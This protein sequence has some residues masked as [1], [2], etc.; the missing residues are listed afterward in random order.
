MGY[1]TGERKQVFYSILL[2]LAGGLVGVALFGLSGYMIS[3]SF[4]EP[5]FFVIILI[6]AV[7]KLFG[8]MKGAFRYIERLLSH[9]ATFQMIG[10]LRLNYFRKSL[11]LDEDTHSARFIQRLNQ[12]FDRVEDYYIRIIY[13]YI[14]AAL[15][16]LILIMLAGYINIE[17]VLLM[18]GASLLL[19]FAVPKLFERL[20]HEEAGRR[21]ETDSTFYMKLYH[22]IHDYTDLFVTKRAKSHKVKLDGYLSRIRHSEDRQ[23]LFDSLMV[24]A[25]NIIQI[26]VLTLIIFTMYREIPMLVPMVMLLALSY[27]D[28]VIPVMQPASRYRSV[29]DAVGE[30]DA[31]DTTRDPATEASEG[32][33]RIYIKGLRY[34]YRGTA[35]DVLKDVTAV[36]DAG[37][38]HALIGSSG[39]GKTTLL[40]SIIE[41]GGSVHLYGGD[42]ETAGTIR[43]DASIMPQ[44]LDFYNATVE[45]NITMFGHMDVS[46]ET[47][48]HHL[49]TLE[50]AY[51]APE[52]MITHTGRLSGGEEKRL[53]FI[54]M[55]VENRKWWIMD[56]PTA[57]LDDRLKQKIWDRVMAQDTVIVSTH[58]LSRLDEFDQIHYMEE[59][60]IIESGNYSSL[61]VRGGA[62]Y[63]AVMR[64]ADKL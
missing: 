36:F 15:L 16:T 38:K 19:L 54:R 23:D 22:Y 34:K 6:I 31:E 5:P 20:N 29:K 10:R 45:D 60:R 53:H 43:Q 24:L 56:E 58:D 52:T 41:G 48:R 8:M 33:G 59:G 55:M 30:L 49:E 61:M 2:G 39:S 50:M 1:L 25:A 51:Y 64:Y 35:A 4:F 12:H 46:P 44:H 47:I 27:F 42:G 37:Q 57:R 17:S 3:L 28:Q 62:V 32:I 40:N 11:A 14:T 21:E 18:T 13:P 26:A 7:I 9:E 63:E